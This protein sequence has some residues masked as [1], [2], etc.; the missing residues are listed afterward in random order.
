MAEKHQDKHMLRILRLVDCCVLIQNL[1][2]D[3]ETTVNPLQEEWIDQDGHLS[4]ADEDIHMSDEENPCHEKSYIHPIPERSKKDI[5]RRQ[6]Q[7][8]LEYKEYIC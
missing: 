1:M 4:D 2:L 7:T 8:Y 5:C 3:I 6:L